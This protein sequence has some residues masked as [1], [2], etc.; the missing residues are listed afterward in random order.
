[1]WA[2][3]ANKVVRGKKNDRRLFTYLE[4][5]RRESILFSEVKKF[6]TLSIKKN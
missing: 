1:M 5:G 3:A 2:I 4:M 6:Y